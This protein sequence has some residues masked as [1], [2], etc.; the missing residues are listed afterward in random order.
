L[1]N[2]SETWPRSGMMRN[3]IAYRLPTLALRINETES[4]SWPTPTARDWKDTGN[5]SNV[6]ENGLLGRFFK[7]RFGINLPPI[8]SEWLMGFPSGWTDCER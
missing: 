1:D 4:G 6:P 8:V 5:L 2:Y 7:N 3:G